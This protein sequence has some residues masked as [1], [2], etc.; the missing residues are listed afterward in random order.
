[1][2][3]TVG[4]L[5]PGDMGSA[6]GGRLARHGVRVV[7]ALDARMEEVYSAV[8]E[9]DGLAWR[10]IP[11][12]RTNGFAFFQ[13]SR[14]CSVMNRAVHASAAQQRLVRRVDDRVYLQLRDVGAQD[15]IEI[16]TQFRKVSPHV[17]MIA[18]S[19]NS[20]MLIVA[21]KLGAVATLKK[22]FAADQLLMAVKEAL[23]QS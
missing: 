20:D 7:V 10:Q 4:I 5:S 13:Q 21:Q 8:F 6:I 18:I 11:A 17:P 1:M 15:G 3:V 16:L 22:P 9:H 19:G 2:S 23:R 14:P 12:L